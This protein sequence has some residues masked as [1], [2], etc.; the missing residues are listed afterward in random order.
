MRIFLLATAMAIACINAVPAFAEDPDGIAGTWLTDDGGAHVK[1]FQ[2]NGTYCGKIVWLKDPLYESDDKEAGKPLR[3]RNN[4]D[5]TKRN[6]P[7]LGLYLLRDFAYKGENLWAD[8]TI[9]NPENGKIYDAKLRLD[10][11]DTLKVRGFIGI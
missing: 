4:P 5:P 2:E 3:D 6:Q 9:Y 1:I 7:Y 11:K 8:G 10:G